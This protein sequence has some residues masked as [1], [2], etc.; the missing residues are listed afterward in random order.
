MKLIVSYC[1]ASNTKLQCNLES[2]IKNSIICLI[3]TNFWLKFLIK[4]NFLNCRKFEIEMIKMSIM[5][6]TKEIDIALFH[7]QNFKYPR[8]FVI[9]MIIRWT[10]I[11]VHN[12]NLDSVFLSLEKMYFI[13]E[14]KE[15]KGYYFLNLCT[16]P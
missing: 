7:I 6:C 13:N 9:Q 8:E 11:S 4:L 14:E 15:R 10:N 12:N 5:N 1:S 3:T 2:C 16:K